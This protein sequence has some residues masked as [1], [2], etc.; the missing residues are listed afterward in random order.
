MKNYIIIPLMLILTMG[1]VY[2]FRRRASSQA[3]PQTTAEQL[4]RK[5]IPQPYPVE[6]RG[7]PRRFSHKAPYRSYV[8]GTPFSDSDPLYS[9]ASNEPERLGIE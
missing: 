5:Y 6:R 3:R 2:A 8:S 4:M 9:G 7:R 1:E